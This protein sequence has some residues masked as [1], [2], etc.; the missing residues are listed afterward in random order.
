[1]YIHTSVR[2]GAVYTLREGGK[3]A[4]LLTQSVPE[5]GD[6]YYSKS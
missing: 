6:E 2:K 1:M 3:V 5:G 4:G